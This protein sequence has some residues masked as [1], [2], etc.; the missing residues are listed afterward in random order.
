MSI[1]NHFIDILTETDD[2]FEENVGIERLVAM[3]DLTNGCVLARSEGAHNF[4]ATTAEFDHICSFFKGPSSAPEVST[5]VYFEEARY[6]VRRSDERQILG[7]KEREKKYFVAFKARMVVVIALSKKYLGDALR[8]NENVRKVTDP[9]KSSVGA[10]IW[11]PLVFSYISQNNSLQSLITA[12]S[13]TS[14]SMNRARRFLL[15]IDCVL[16][17]TYDTEQIEAVRWSKYLRDLSLEKRSAI[18]EF[19]DMRY[20]QLS[21]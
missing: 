11:T 4:Q 2:S 10:M 21:V 17:R 3:I 9:K 1:W 6:I 5:P 8:I 16:L 15:E 18:V 19:L 13:I 12:K 20:R 7:R 14:W